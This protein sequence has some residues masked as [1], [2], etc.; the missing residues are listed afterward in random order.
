[1]KFNLNTLFGLCDTNTNELT[2]SSQGVDF[3]VIPPPHFHRLL[4]S[5]CLSSFFSTKHMIVRSL[6]IAPTRSTMI[7]QFSVEFLHG[8]CFELAVGIPAEL[9]MVMTKRPIRLRTVLTFSD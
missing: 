4:Q 8:C 6:M 2:Y 3:R 7:V 9:W 5:S 1:M